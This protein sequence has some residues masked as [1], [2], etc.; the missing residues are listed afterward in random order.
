MYPRIYFGSEM[1]DALLQWSENSIGEPKMYD[2][3]M[4]RISYDREMIDAWIHCSLCNVKIHRLVLNQAMLVD[5]GYLC[6]RCRKEEI[7]KK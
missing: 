7:A 6:M 5:R 3:N 1:I 4:A 2:R